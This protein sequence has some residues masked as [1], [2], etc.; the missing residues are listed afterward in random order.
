MKH[1]INKRHPRRKLK[2]G[3]RVPLKWC[4]S[5]TGWHCCGCKHS[6]LG[7]MGVGVTV[8]FKML[9]FL[10]ILFLWFFLLSLPSFLFY[11]SGN[12]ISTEKLTLKHI[13]TAFSLGNIGQASN[14]CNY[15]DCPY[16]FSQELNI[17]KKCNLES[18]GIKY[19]KQIH[20]RFDEECKEINKRALDP[21]GLKPQIYAEALCQNLYVPI[22]F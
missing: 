7:E 9:K 14:A 10:M 13:I 8:Y 21:R 20:K 3:Q 12:Q 5:K 4:G 2:N 18:M 17:D 1:V 6:D 22:P 15:G 11:Y 19:E 16:D